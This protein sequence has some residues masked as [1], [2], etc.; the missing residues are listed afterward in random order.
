[1]NNPLPKRLGMK[2][3]AFPADRLLLNPREGSSCI[4][5]IKAGC[6]MQTFSEQR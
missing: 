1:M 2:C 6:F 5:N 3:D 4:F